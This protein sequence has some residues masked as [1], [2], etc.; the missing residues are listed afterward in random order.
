FIVDVFAERYQRFVLPVLIVFTLLTNTLGL[1]PIMAN[2]V[3]G[4]IDAAD[5]TR[6]EL[7]YHLLGTTVAG[8]YIPRW[9]KDKPFISPEA[10]ALALGGTSPDVHVPTSD[11]SIQV[12]R[13]LKATNEQTFDVK[14]PADG[15]IVL[16]TAYFP[17]WRAEVNGE[18]V[19]AG[20]TQPAGL[21]AVQV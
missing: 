16:N 14:A 21:I 2:T 18:P 10:L 15:R 3:E 7:M 13:L 6:F 8:E 17:G 5:S 19:E 1:R 12:T 20:I 11:P 9:V 4:D